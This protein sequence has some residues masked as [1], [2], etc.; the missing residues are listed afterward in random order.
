MEK[1]IS[2][3]K[4]ATHNVQVIHRNMYGVGFLSAH[5]L[6]ETYYNYLQERTDELIELFMTLGFN[7]P[8]LDKALRTSDSLEGE[9]IKFTAGLATIREIFQD[10]MVQ[11]DR[12][13]ETLPG[14]ISE[15]LEDFKVWLRKE[16]N[17]TLARIL[18][19]VE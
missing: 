13:K 7:E 19:D 8:G 6:S 17:F 14:D 18:S 4:I 12:T 9:K 2:M 5:E 11:I 1:L 15:V 16:A 10:L 3:L